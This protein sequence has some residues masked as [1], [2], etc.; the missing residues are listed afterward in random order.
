MRIMRK[1]VMLVLIIALII[2][3]GQAFSADTSKTIQV[4]FA[5]IHYVI[6]GID[7]A[8]PEA[9]LG[10]IYTGNTYVPLRFVASILNKAIAWD[11][12]NSKVTV[13]A[14][15]SEDWETIRDYLSAQEVK[16]SSIQ[17]VDKS[18]M[19]LTSILINTRE[20]SYEFDGQLVEPNAKT[21]GLF[22][23]NSI[24][25]PLRFIYES[26]GY[27]PSFDA[28]TYVIETSTDAELLAYQT[29]VKTNDKLIVDKKAACEAELL[30]LGLNFL[31]KQKTMTDEE[32]EAFF[33]QAEGILVDCKSELNVMLDELTEQ[34]T[35]AGQPT[36]IVAQYLE[37]I[38][39]REAWGR[40][41][42]ETYR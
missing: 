24:Y 23:N 39:A 26:L 25:V 29:I 5:P 40:D 32:K 6:D 2:P 28:S 27:Q 15:T 22:Y 18:T 21:P 14:P 36:D 42:V 13:A 12:P 41:L 20:V 16:D 37:A 30:S 8:P 34:L 10:F 17:P 7:Y 9:Q 38:E 3:A 1:W 19:T 4:S 11:G 31:A 35:D 33:Q